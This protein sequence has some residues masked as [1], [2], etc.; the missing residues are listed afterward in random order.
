I[1]NIYTAKSDVRVVYAMC[2]PDTENWGKVIKQHG[3]HKIL[4]AGHDWLPQTLNLIGQGWIPW[5]LGESPYDM[6]YTSLR[7][8][9]EHVAQG[10][11]LPTGVLFAKSVFATKKNLAQ[12][13]K[14]PD[15][16][17]G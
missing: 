16:K 10:K 9:Y 12:I 4:I 7:L 8:V 17:G 3:N 1:K 2:A 15:A 14:S 5:S 6:G 13:R 11:P